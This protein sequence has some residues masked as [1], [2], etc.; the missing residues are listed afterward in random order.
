MPNP[1]TGTVAVDISKAVQEVKRG[2]VEYRV[3]KDGNMHVSIARVSCDSANII[4]YLTALCELIVKVRPS[5]VKGT[6]IKNAVIHTT[7]G[8]SIKITFAGR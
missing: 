6:N 2:K 8:P 1:K 3:D 7:M 5:S 4:D